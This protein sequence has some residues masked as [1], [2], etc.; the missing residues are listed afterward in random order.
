LLV[1]VVA[2][3]AGIVLMDPPERVVV[4]VGKVLMVVLKVEVAA[5][6]VAA[7]AHRPITALQ[8]AVRYKVAKVEVL[9]VIARLAVV[10]VLDIM[11][12]AAVMPVVAVA[13]LVTHP[14][15]LVGVAGLPR[16]ILAVVVV[17][18]LEVP[19]LLEESIFSFNWITNG[20]LRYRTKRNVKHGF[21]IS[22]YG[23]S[24]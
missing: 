24:H 14:L 12:A 3:L 17:A 19:I 7:V 18:A 11:A 22:N 13:V 8:R 20:R 4:V 10:A 15:I 1:E 6:N 2:P 16:A 23:V 9:P 5:P 21:T